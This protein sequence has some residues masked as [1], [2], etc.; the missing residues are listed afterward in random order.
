VVDDVE[1]CS[2]APELRAIRTRSNAAMP[3]LP[4]SARSQSGF[5]E[6]DGDENDVT[7][8]KRDILLL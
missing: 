1:R 6:V 7:A 2:H 3:S 8:E 4:K 5:K